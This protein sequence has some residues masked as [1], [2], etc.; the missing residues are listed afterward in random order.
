MATPAAAR[1]EEFTLRRETSAGAGTYS[2]L[3]IAKAKKLSFKKNFDDVT[4]IDCTD[5][6]TNATWRKSV[7][8]ES[9]VD[10]TFTGVLDKTKIA[11]FRTDFAATATYN[12]Q[13]H[14]SGTGAAGGGTWT[15]AFFLESF[16]IGAADATGMVSVDVSLR[17]DGAVTWVAAV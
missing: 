8:K 2:I 4:T 14:F 9:M 16:E 7:P 6:L 12:Y 3:C 5:P 10:L 1:G 15:G 13:A 11:E 17:S